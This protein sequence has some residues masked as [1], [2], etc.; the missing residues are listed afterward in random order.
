[1]KGGVLLTTKIRDVTNIFYQ[2]E[3]TLHVAEIDAHDALYHLSTC[4]EDT[5]SN[6]ASSGYMPLPATDLF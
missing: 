2:V 3:Y 1:M 4:H 6:D 5:M